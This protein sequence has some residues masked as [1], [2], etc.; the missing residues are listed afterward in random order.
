MKGKYE[1]LIQLKYNSYE[2]DKIFENICQEVY[3]N[4]SKKSIIIID[5]F[6]KSVSQLLINIKLRV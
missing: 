6:D 4:L 5:G 3:K 2:S 1:R